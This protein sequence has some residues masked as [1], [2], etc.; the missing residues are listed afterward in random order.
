[1]I[2]MMDQHGIGTDASIPQHIK[3]VCDR[4]YVDV[5]GPTGE[6]GS[7]GQV[8]VEQEP[9]K[10]EEN[11]SK[12]RIGSEQ[13]STDTD[14]TGHDDGDQIKKKQGSGANKTK[15]EIEKD[16]QNTLKTI[17]TYKPESMISYNV[18]GYFCQL[19]ILNSHLPH[20]SV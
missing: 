19:K 6:D 15:N 2:A 12:E 7:R 11:T 20:F 16:F 9:W 17:C 13:I 4:H 10:R 5:C 3:N 14:D 18:K 1:M 8:W